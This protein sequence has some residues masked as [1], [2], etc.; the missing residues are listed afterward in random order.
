MFYTVF[1][2]EAD[3]TD[4]TMK[5]LEA[6]PRSVLNWR[7][8]AGSTPLHLVR[9]ESKRIGEERR[10][11]KGVRERGREEKEGRREKEKKKGREREGGREEK[12]RRGEKQGEEER[13]IRNLGS[14]GSERRRR[15]NVHPFSLFFH[16]P[17]SLFFLGS[18]VCEGSERAAAQNSKKYRS[19][20]TRTRCANNFSFFSPEIAI[21]LFLFWYFKLRFFLFRCG[22]T[23][24]QLGE[25]NSARNRKRNRSTNND[26][27]TSHSH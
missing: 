17:S 10:E 2:D 12:W 26:V 20:F 11:G 6:S 13:K 16:S 23:F 24:N 21:S 19:D 27:I 7:N 8:S 14:R 5:I 18:F 9:E 25:T 1:L 15:Q 3:S 4:L 22:R